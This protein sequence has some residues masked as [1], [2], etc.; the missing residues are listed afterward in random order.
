MASPALQ[1]FQKNGINNSATNF[2]RS[3]RSLATFRTTGDFSEVTKCAAATSISTVTPSHSTVI[4][5][6]LGTSVLPSDNS[7]IKPI[8][9]LISVTLTSPL[10]KQ[11]SPTPNF[12]PIQQT[13]KLHHNSSNP[14][15]ASPNPKDANEG[16]DLTKVQLV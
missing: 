15:T 6:S 8:M 5:A 1:M 7:S 13:T 11:H 16:N 4:Y 9:F 3:P 12:N 2:H 14:S 10:V